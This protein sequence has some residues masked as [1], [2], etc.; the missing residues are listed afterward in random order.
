MNDEHISL[1]SRAMDGLAVRHRV[2][3]SNLANQ[4][5]P[6]YKRRD[7]TFEDQLERAMKG[8]RFEPKITVD[9]SAG[10]ADG[11]NVVPEDEVGILTRLEIVYRL[12]SRDVTHR[13]KLMRDAMTGN[14]G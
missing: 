12:L 13:A 4:T 9:S 8:E 1:V 2:I 6:G 5:T 14:R 11:N 10:N 7:V 3:A